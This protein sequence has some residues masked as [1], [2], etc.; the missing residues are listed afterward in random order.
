MVSPM[1]QSVQLLAFF[2]SN[3]LFF[4]RSFLPVACG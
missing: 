3:F 2:F 1:N 4:W